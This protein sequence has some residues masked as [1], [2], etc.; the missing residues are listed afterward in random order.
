MHVAGP[1]STT[2]IV[3]MLGANLAIAVAKL[4]AAAWTN[5]SAMLSEAIHTLIGIFSESLQHAGLRRSRRLDH[6]GPDAHAFVHER[7]KAFWGLLVGVLLY[8]MGA[9]VSIYDGVQKF[10]APLP[11]IDAHFNYI[12]LAAAMVVSAYGALQ[13][14]GRIGVRAPG[15]SLFDAL[16]DRQDPALFS[17]VLKNIAAMAGLIV[18]LAGI[19][20][21]H[22]GGYI[23]ADGLASIAIGLV[24]ALVAI[25][26][27]I[28][29]RS[30]ITVTDVAAKSA[31]TGDGDEA[32]GTPMAGIE[33]PHERTAMAVAKFFVSDDGEPRESVIIDAE[34]DPSAPQSGAARTRKAKKNRRRS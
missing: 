16:K 28:E 20:A 2:G 17:D 4:V 24:M 1:Q 22:L 3:L 26:L 13:S 6:T 30:H 10:V 9:G 8:S 18:A 11:L 23:W 7:E 15:N 12:V 32:D 31:H 29:L 21:A 5:S 19:M 33:A 27:A 34:L 25:L 14:I